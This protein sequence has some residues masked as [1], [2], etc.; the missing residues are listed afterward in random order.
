VIPRWYGLFIPNRAFDVDLW[1]VLM[2]DTVYDIRLER[3]LLC[4]QFSGC[5]LQRH[6][7]ILV[8]MLRFAKRCLTWTMIVWMQPFEDLAMILGH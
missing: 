4:P 6:G 3:A 8:L 1:D 7:G 2:C 5:L